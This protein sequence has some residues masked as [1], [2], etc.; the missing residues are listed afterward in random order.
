MSRLIVK[1]WRGPSKKG[2]D[3]AYLQDPQNGGTEADR[4]YA[5]CS[6]KSFFSN[7]EDKM[8]NRFLRTW[9]IGSVGF[10]FVG[11]LIP[12]LMVGEAKGPIQY[13]L[14]KTAD[15]VK[16]ANPKPAERFRLEIIN[17]KNE[18]AKQMAAVMI[19]LPS[20]P[21]GGKVAYHYHKN[22]ES[23][24]M[25]IDGEA[26]EYVE[27]KAI[28]LKAGDLIYLAPMAKH[29]IVNTSGKDCRY[30]EFYA[31]SVADVVRVK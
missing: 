15:F 29:S 16:M 6:F 28:P 26:T 1:N 5:A 21:P 30:M 10:F 9:M 13:K 18:N 12:S 25:M 8:K 27:G 22:R 14:M 19:I 2:G 17:N 23:V 20:S 31:P 11:L 4:D 3:G 7:K 24:I